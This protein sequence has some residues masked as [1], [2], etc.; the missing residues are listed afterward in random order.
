MSDGLASGPAPEPERRTGLDVLDVLSA[1]RRLTIDDHMFTVEMHPGFLVTCR[2]QLFTGAGVRPVA[3]ATQ[4]PGDGLGVTSAAEWLAAAVWQRYCPGEELPPVWIHLKLMRG[5]KLG[6]MGVRHG[7]FTQ[8]GRYWPQDPRFSTIT[9]ERLE[10]LVGVP[11]AVDRGAGY[12]PRPEEPEGKR[13]FAEFAVV[14]F[15]QPEPFR[16]PVCM[17]AGVTWWRRWVRQVLPRRGARSCCW[18]HRGDWH[19]VSAMA[20]DV[21]RR[22][23]ARS[24]YPEE[25]EEFAVAH[26]VAAGATRWESEALATL[27]D[28]EDAIRPDREWGYANGQ[29]RAQAMLEAGVRRTVVLRVVER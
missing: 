18:Y 23:R 28:T 25:M 1:P 12:V 22:A 4:I 2:L 17:P 8:T 21:L 26:A 19:T 24:V 27:F 5:G 20:R 6:P 7:Q 10:A 3:V 13:V 15:A 14:R 11:V 29:H 16:A 9:P